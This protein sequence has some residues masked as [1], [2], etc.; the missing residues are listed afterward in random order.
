MSPS[1]YSYSPLPMVSCLRESN[2]R[3]SRLWLVFLLCLLVVGLLVSLIIFAVKANSKGCKDGLR[4]QQECQNQTDHLQHQLTVAQEVLQRTKAQYTVCN[5]TVEN[6]RD[7]LE[8]EKTQSQKQLKELQGEIKRLN[9]KLQEASE[10]AERLR[11]AF[12]RTTVNSGSFSCS[13]SSSLLF[14]AVVV[15]G[16][17]ALLT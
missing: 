10:E 15:L 2:L 1:L 4:A 13:S 6:L 3:D 11:K 16:L 8:M 12:R 17:N 9:Q 5:Q 14:I 7:S